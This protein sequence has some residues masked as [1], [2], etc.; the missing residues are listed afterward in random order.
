MIAENIQKIKSTLPAH[1]CLVAVSKTKPNAMIE[2]AYQVGHRD[3]GENK[4]QDLVAKYEALPKD[5]QWHFIGHLQTNK[6]KYMAPFI[7]LIHGVDSLKLLKA[8]NK[9]G[10]KNNR[11]IDCL[12]QVKI[13]EEESK[14][15]L[16]A[17]DVK[18]IIASD[19]YQ[20]FQN[21][22]IRGLMGM[23]T[24]TDDENQVKA[25]FTS[26][27]ALFEDL[28]S[29]IFQTSHFDTLSM[30]MS[31]DYPL[32]VECGSTMVRVGSSIFGAR[33]YH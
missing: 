12:L 23:S 24:N 9:E 30:G 17:N 2:E 7:H 8:I 22:R 33:N 32:A 5:I 25:E 28:K 21:I 1:V 29:S 27:H 6:V 15:G 10:V 19:E 13:A 3:F 18:T 26:L 4:V 11:T 31:N 20:Q 14:F 16:S